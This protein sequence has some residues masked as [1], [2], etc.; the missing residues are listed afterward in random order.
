ERVVPAMTPDEPATA[1]FHEAHD[2]GDAE[3]DAGSEVL[4][5]WSSPDGVASWPL[6][7][8]LARGLLPDPLPVQARFF[9]TP[10]VA[11]QAER[12]LGR[13]VTVMPQHETLLLAARSLWNVLQFELTPR[14]KGV[15][16]LSD[17]WRRLMA[18]Q[19][20]PARIGALA[21][22]AVQILGL[23]LWAWQQKQQLQV[24]RAQMTVVLKQAHP[25]VQV[26]LDAPVQMQRETD[27]LRAQAGQPGDSDLET[28]MAAVASAWPVGRPTGLLLYDGSMLTVTPPAGWGMADLE[29][30]RAQLSASG[31]QVE[32]GADGRLTVRRAPRG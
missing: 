21:L 25:Q 15:Y 11:A 32:G 27:A 14:S 1:F 22:V 13:A 2:V 19:W 26:V 28:L 3:A 30:L 4:L 6:A 24:K 8:S 29:Q 10:P 5:T 12:W 31:F 16:A 17:R 9:A 18:P 7:G 23:N 20:R